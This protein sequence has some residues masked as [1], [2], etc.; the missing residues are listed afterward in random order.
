VLYLF[1]FVSISEIWDGG[2]CWVTDWMWD[3]GRINKTRHIRCAKITQKQFIQKGLQAVFD[4]IL[5]VD[6]GW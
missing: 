6:G 1:S 2:L 3:V 5:G 4:L